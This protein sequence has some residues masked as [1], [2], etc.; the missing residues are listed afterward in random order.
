[1]HRL[2]LVP[3]DDL[4]FYWPLVCK[5]I[6]SALDLS[7]GESDIEDILKMLQEEE[8]GLWIAWSQEL[9]RPVAC[10]TTMIQDYPK[11]KVCTIV[12]FG[13]DTFLEVGNLIPK[14]QR[15]AKEQGCQSM[16]VYGR[17]AWVKRLTSYGFDYR[18]TC[19]E[20]A[21]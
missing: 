17:K 4:D 11:K 3:K 16:R 6:Q 9:K 14:I 13:G 8:L 2:Y 10:C 1:L 15:Y 21:L 19:V 18:F 7:N 12:H 5:Y 20:S